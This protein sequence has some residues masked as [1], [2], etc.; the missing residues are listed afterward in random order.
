MF[1]VRLVFVAWLCTQVSTPSDDAICLNYMWVFPLPV[2]MT[3][4]T[5]PL[6]LSSTISA[7]YDRSKKCPSLEFDAEFSLLLVSLG[8]SMAT[9]D[10]NVFS[11][12]GIGQQKVK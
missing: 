1:L 3:T 5:F 7:W 9:T 4:M 10:Q 8:E 12:Q 2:S 6:R 11:S